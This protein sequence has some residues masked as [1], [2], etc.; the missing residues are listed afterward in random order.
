M[1]DFLTESYK[2]TTRPALLGAVMRGA[3]A[4]F[5]SDAQRMLDI[6]RSSAFKFRSARLHGEKS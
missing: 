1:G 3:N 6:T 5:E 2:R 4:K